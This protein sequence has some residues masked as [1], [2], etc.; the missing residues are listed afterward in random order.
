MQ[1]IL[2]FYPCWLEKQPVGGGYDRD[3]FLNTIRIDLTYW[4]TTTESW[5]DIVIADH[6]SIVFAILSV[7]MFFDTLISIRKTVVN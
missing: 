2:L 7:V 6:S 4:L 3:E 1:I 5:H